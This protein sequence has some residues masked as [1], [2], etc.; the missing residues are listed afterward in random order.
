MHRIDPSRLQKLG[1]R[2]AY[3]D[4]WGHKT[5][6]LMTLT[7]PLPLLSNNHYCCCQQPSKHSRSFITTSFTVVGIT[8]LMAIV[9]GAALTIAKAHTLLQLLY[10]FALCLLLL[11]C[12]LF[13]FSA[14]LLTMYF[15]QILQRTADLF[16][17]LNDTVLKRVLLIKDLL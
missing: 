14:A 10:C 12:S 6:H 15:L 9:A 16:I 1:L 5:T 13:C 3:V 11:F 2:T 7:L 8:T 17:V 4:L